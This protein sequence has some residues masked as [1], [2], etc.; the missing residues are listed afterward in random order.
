MNLNIWKIATILLVLTVIIMGIVLIKDNIN[1]VGPK[2]AVQKALDFINKSLSANGGATATLDSID[3][4]KIKLYKFTVD[5]NGEKY[6]SYISSDGKLLFPE[7]GININESVTFLQKEGA[8]VC[9]ENDK[10]IVY[11]F[12]SKQ[13]PHCEWEKPIIESVV[14][15]FGDAVSFHENIDLDKDQDVFA[16]YSDGGVPAIIIGCKYYRVGSGE[17]LGEEQEKAL[18]TKTICSVTGNIPAEICNQ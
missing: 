8:E 14:Q 5:I 4:G 15:K 13:C 7:D 6:P 18:L 3:S 2:A 11:F 10:P 12:G 9:K 17:A 1:D 16:R